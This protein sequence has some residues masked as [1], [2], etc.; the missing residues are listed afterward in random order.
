MVHYES[1]MKK[2]FALSLL[3]SF[4]CNAIAYNHSPLTP[5]WFKTIYQNVNEDKSNV[6]RGTVVDV[7]GPT[8]VTVKNLYDETIEVEL[9][10]LTPKKNASRDQINISNTAL[11]KLVGSQVYILGKNNSKSISAKLLDATGNDINLS[12][13]GTGAFEINTTSLLFKIEKQQYINAFNNA[14]KS[15]VGIWH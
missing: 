5:S 12:F 9:L 14:K 10:H 4:S 2:Y 3:L 13:V 8:T 1:I 6:W 15:K 11:Q 7:I